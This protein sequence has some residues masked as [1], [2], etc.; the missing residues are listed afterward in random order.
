MSSSQPEP[1]LHHSSS[2]A[3]E[4]ER[5][6]EREHCVCVCVCVCVCALRREEFGRIPS[7]AMGY[8]GSKVASGGKNERRGPF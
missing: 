3:V 2:S 5:E 8:G 1:G 7:G 4:R 6:R